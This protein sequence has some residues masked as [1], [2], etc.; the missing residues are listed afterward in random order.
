MRVK[1]VDAPRKQ[2]VKVA[3]AAHAEVAEVADLA[4]A[5]FGHSKGFTSLCAIPPPEAAIIPKL[6]ERPCRPRR[7]LG[8]TRKRH[9][10]SKPSVIALIIWTKDSGRADLVPARGRCRIRRMHNLG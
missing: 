1:I 8:L 6:L 9:M 2:A 4:S 3:E 7:R 5:L 10:S